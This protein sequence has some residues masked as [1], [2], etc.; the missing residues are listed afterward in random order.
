MASSEATEPAAPPRRAYVAHAWLTAPVFTVLEREA[1]RRRLHP[2]QLAAAIVD[3]VIVGGYVD[4]LL[5]RK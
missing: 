3:V 4:A 2:D 1:A 5:D